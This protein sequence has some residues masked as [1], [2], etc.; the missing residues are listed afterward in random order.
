MRHALAPSSPSV[1]SELCFDEFANRREM[2]ICRGVKGM[3]CDECAIR[4]VCAL[5]LFCCW[6]ECVCVRFFG[7]SLN[8]DRAR[9]L[10]S[11][12]LRVRFEC[13]RTRTPPIRL[14]AGSDTEMPSCRAHMGGLSNLCRAL[15]V[16][17]QAAGG[18]NSHVECT[19]CN[20]TMPM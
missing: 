9:G 19:K 14:R 7:G 6:L 20:H 16:P 8:S 13:A 3:R 17:G 1:E 15:I 18:G 11:H 10:L 5:D 12:N 2:L 4:V